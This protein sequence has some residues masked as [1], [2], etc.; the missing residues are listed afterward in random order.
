MQ[1]SGILSALDLWEE[2]DVRRSTPLLL[3]LELGPQYSFQYLRPAV[4]ILQALWEE[5]HRPSV[6]Y[7]H[8]E[9]LQLLP[10]ERTGFENSP[11]AFGSISLCLTV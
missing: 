3:E 9:V 8:L 1:Q 5:H 6:I 7:L 10:N 2:N 11:L 4:I